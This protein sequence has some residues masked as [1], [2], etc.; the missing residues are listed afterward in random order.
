M[1]TS[2]RQLPARAA[3]A[4]AALRVIAP[5]YSSLSSPLS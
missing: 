4:C 1:M 3:N 5:S 2:D